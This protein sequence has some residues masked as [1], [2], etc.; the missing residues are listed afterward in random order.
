M[1][2]LLYIQRYVCVHAFMFLIVGQTA[3]PIGT[4]LGIRIHLDPRSVLE[5]Q[6]EGQGQSTASVKMEAP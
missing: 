1:H 3:G 5:S 4:K 6:G 2:N